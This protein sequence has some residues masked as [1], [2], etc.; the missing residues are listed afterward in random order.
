VTI[1]AADPQHKGTLLAGTSAAALFRS[2]DWADS[3]TRLPFPAE[4]R[5]TLHAVVID[6]T[7]A[8][9]YLVAVTSENAE[10]AGVYRSIDAGAS[11]ERLPALSRK[12]VWS[13]AYWPT[14]G[15]V[16]AAGTQDGVF[17]TRDGGERWVQIS[18][19][20]SA[21]PKPVVSLAFDPAHPSIL[22]AGTPHL[23][24]KT[25]NGGAT[26]RALRR[27]MEEDSDIFSI[28]VD[29]TR[30]GRLF[31]GAC[32]GLYRSLDGGNSWTSLERAVGAQ[33]R[34]YVVAG[35][36]RSAN[37]FLVGTN[38]GIFQSLD[39]GATWRKIS[40]PATHSIT[41]DVSNPRRVIVATDQGILRSDDGGDHFILQ[42]LFE[43][44]RRLETQKVSAS[45]ANDLAPAAILKAR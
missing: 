4:L 43:K 44:A 11:W 8:N 7:R 6:P 1:V 31:A 30:P 42:G 40:A 9:V 12:Q 20:D 36:P 25:T 5:S 29:K 13:L 28:A 37:V 33:F 18:S 17:L 16:I 14:D 3:W 21:G 34:T 27:G 24:W 2:Q 23:S 35:Q 19:S 22:Y 10:Y 38:A 26:W 41:F 45:S 32:S 15:N 39:A